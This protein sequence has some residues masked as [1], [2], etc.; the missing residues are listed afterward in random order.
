MPVNTAKLGHYSLCA[1]VLLITPLPVLAT[2]QL[3]SK[4]LHVFCQ[5]HISWCLVG[6]P[7]AATLFVHTAGP[8]LRLDRQSE[9]LV[10]AQRYGHPSDRPMYCSSIS[11][12]KMQAV[13]QS[14][15][16]Y[17]F[18]GLA[19]RRGGWEW[20]ELHHINNAVNWEVREWARWLWLAMYL[21]LGT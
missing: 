3:K 5:G 11:P 6:F 1:W 18:Q 17:A 7:A 4:C 8:L 16:E 20:Q 2:L 19:P 15:L 13:V 14:F 10:K 9:R 12:G 21:C